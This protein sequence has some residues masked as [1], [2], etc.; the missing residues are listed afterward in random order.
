MSTVSSLAAASHVP[1]P[2]PPPG[3]GAPRGADKPKA[4]DAGASTGTSRT[5]NDK[6]SNI[7]NILA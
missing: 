2:G 5:V 4:D 7:V 3:S 6:S 1:P